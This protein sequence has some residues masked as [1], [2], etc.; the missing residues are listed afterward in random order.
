VLADERGGS[1]GA[2]SARSLPPAGGTLGPRVVVASL[3]V[4]GSTTGYALAP[5]V[6]LVMPM[7]AIVQVLSARPGAVHERGLVPAMAVAGALPMPVGTWERVERVLVAVP[8]LFLGFGAAAVLA[9]PPWRDVLV[10]SV[11]PQVEWSAP[12][13]DGAVALLGTTLTAYAYVWESI[14][15]AKGRPALE[16]LGSVQ[17]DA[18][19]GTVVADVS[20]WFILVASAATLGARHEPVATAAD[21]ARAL[22]PVAG[23]WAP[24]VGAIAPLGSAL[25]A[26]PV[27]AAGATIGLAGVSP[28][29]LL[30]DGS[31]AGGIAT[32]VTLVFMMLAATDRT[33]REVA[34]VPAPLVAAGWAV[35]GVVTAAA[36][37]FLVRALAGGCVRPP[38][39]RATANLPL[40]RRRRYNPGAMADDPVPALVRRAA[41]LRRHVVTVAAAQFA[42]LGGAM[43]CADLMAALFFHWLRLDESAGPRDH[44]ILSK[45]HAVHA[46]HACLVERGVL[47]AAELPTS[48]M[49]GSRLAGHPTRR[50]PGVEFAT[51]SL[52]HGLSVGIGI[53]LAE[54]L[55]KTGARTAV[56]LGDGECQEGTVWEAALSAPRFGLE[57]LVAIV[58]SNGFQAGGAV[59]DVMPLEPLGAKWRAFG[60]NVHEI[61]GHDMRAIVAALAAVPAAKGPTAIVAR[62][63]KG[64]GV[65][66]VEGTSRAHY[67]SLSEDEARA[68]L[69]ALEA[70]R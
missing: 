22:A 46:L 18:V 60:W 36:A 10:A 47:D 13:V 61:D 9:H 6:V 5:L 1:R 52:G 55:R 8:L 40:P 62:T 32:P 56:L 70:A 4:V 25:L 57:R 23:R 28:I 65:P 66:G 41:V 14:T 45:G 33:T 48:G 64:K 30:F 69:A 54:R 37:A 67:T 15:V 16:R 17:A 27:L 35:T 68:T 3:A 29:R 58:D 53:A 11:V 31:I 59:D 42:H 38:T 19:L 49:P 44:F 26:L 43:S 51:G 24:V 7:L 21:A 12:F 20:F 34:P 63:V 39:S 2:R 50:A